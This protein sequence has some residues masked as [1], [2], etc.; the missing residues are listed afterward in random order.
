MKKVIMERNYNSF[1]NEK[2]VVKIIRKYRTDK[3]STIIFNKVYNFY[4][5]YV[6]ENGYGIIMRLS[7]K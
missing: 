7:W 2:D 1:D 5:S 3:S 4:N 6:M